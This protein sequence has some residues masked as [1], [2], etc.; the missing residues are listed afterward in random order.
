ME[1]LQIACLGTRIDGKKKTTALQ[2]VDCNL[3]L[4]GEVTY[5]SGLKGIY[6]GQI[7]TARGRVTDDRICEINP[8]SFSYIDTI[9]EEDLLKYKLLHEAAETEYTALTQSRRQ[10]SD[11]SCILEQLEP[12][13]K[14]YKR[15]N[16]TGR[17]AFEVR[18][19][20]Y[21]RNGKDV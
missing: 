5:F 10:A 19:L 3:N 17:L 18:V 12:L 4:T 21:L 9:S 2:Q 8:N 11:K 16:A 15:T 6:C 13:R 1:A 20:N 14:A 7:Y